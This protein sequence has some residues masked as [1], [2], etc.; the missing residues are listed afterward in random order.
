MRKLETRKVDCDSGVSYERE[1]ADFDRG[2]AEMRK[3]GKK[4]QASAKLVDKPA[5]TLGGCHADR[6]EG[7]VREV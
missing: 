5:Y 3:E 4:Y 7:G 2:V 1:L 6:E